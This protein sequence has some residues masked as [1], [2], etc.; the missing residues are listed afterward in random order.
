VT[1]P[2][3]FIGELGYGFVNFDS[4]AFLP[5]G[6]FPACFISRVVSAPGV[7]ICID[8]SAG[9]VRFASVVEREFTTSGLGD[10]SESC[11]DGDLR[12]HVEIVV[13]IKLI[14]TQY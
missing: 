4:R 11:D 13:L 10:N 1:T 8:T 7:S 5:G 12:E 6:T 14:I 2:P 3:V 9:I